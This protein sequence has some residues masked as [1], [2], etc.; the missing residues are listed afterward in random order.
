MPEPVRAPISGLAPAAIIGPQ[1]RFS[2]LIQLREAARIDGE[3]DGEIFATETVW[4]GETGR[5][6]ASIEA[7][8]V[9]VAGDPARLDLLHAARADQAVIFVLA[10]DDVEASLRTAETVRKHFPHL[11][12]YARARNRKHAYRLMDLE[13]EVIQRETF[14]SSVD[15][16]RNVL[17]GLGLSHYDAD[18]VVETFKEYD[19][20]RLHSSYE[21]H[22]DEEK[23]VM[24][25]KK[26]AE[27]LEE[28]F[29][30]D[31]EVEPN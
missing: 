28:L 11:K 3:I 31:V 14:L 19:E 24:L 23:M 22:N 29:A 8:E 2:G 26:S 9:V 13:V 30:Q 16:A 27:E 18:Q 25:A 12:I 17:E 6:H 1:T 10:I 21:H 15:I 7:P 4:I 5:V 20:Q